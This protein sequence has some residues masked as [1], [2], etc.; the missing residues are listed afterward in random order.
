[1]LKVV[2]QT[3]Y[4][5]IVKNIL[6]VKLRS[7][8]LA[9]SATAHPQKIFTINKPDLIKIPPPKKKTFLDYIFI[10]QGNMSDCW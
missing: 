7:I 3:L 4:W 6:Y 10:M 5:F 1:M 9:F 2:E 8:L